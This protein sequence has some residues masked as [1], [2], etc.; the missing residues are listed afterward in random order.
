METQHTCL[1]AYDLFK[2][3]SPRWADMPGVKGR[4][5]YMSSNNKVINRSY[6][7]AD[8]LLIET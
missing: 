3:P 6:L 7:K 4:E 1:G 5:A 2:E 8:R